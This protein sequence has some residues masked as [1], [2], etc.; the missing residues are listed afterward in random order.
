M[1]LKLRGGLDS[2]FVTILLGILIGS[3]AIFGIGSSAFN[4]NNQQVAAVGDTP[5]STETYYRRVQNRANGL[6]AQFGAQYT[7]PQLIS[8]LQI[9]QQVLQQMISEAALIEHT[10]S[11]GLRAGNAELRKELE[12]Y[13]GFVLPDGTLSKE[14]VLQAINNTGLTRT[15]FMNEV[16][17]SISQRK[18]IDTLSNDTMMPR[19]YAEAL[20]VWQAERRRATLIDI[21]AADIGDIP[22]PTDAELQGYYDLNK[23]AYRTDERR[24]YN[25]VLV[26]PQQFMADIKLDEEKVIAEYESR[27]DYYVQAER[28]GIQQVSFADKAAADA[29]LIA[30]NAGAEFVEAAASVTDFTAEEIE[31]GEFQK[32][33][34]VSTYNQVTADT[35]F[36]LADGAVTRP[37]KGLGGWNVFKVASITAAE[38]KSLEDVR[39]EIEAELKGFEAEE[40]MYEALDAVS[41]A[42]GEDTDLA[43]IAKASKLPLAT[44]TGVT[45]R[46]LNQNGEP[47]ATQQSEFTILRDA[48]SKEIGLEADMAD[49][50][51]RDSGKGFY[52]VEVTDII[53][54]A[55]RALED[56]KSELTKAWTQEQKLAK[57]SKIA[58]DAKNKLAAGADAETIAIDLN[59]TSFEAKNVA[60]T[61]DSNSSLSPSIRRLIFDLEKG[62]IDYD[63]AADGSGY[64]VVRVDDVTP[65]NPASRTAAVDKLLAQ[66]NGEAATE[67]YTQYR[68]YLLKT[69][70]ITVNNTLQQ[71][72]FTETLQQ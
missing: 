69:Y 72:L 43:L 21:K 18:L 49:I 66:L 62:G 24:T 28:R 55:D 70:D 56:I 22:A 57:A 17:A 54:P 31:L 44:V 36:A 26:T 61:G 47:V 46:G 33:E 15:D 1:L 34:L 2:I 7:T 40:H 63:R 8:M 5:I 65:G 48:F 29:F 16:R 42:M 68:N 25:Y 41:K 14:M 67:I 12:T 38:E 10:T 50:D 4:S 3:F 27:A 32:S 35:I 6:Q 64:I 53:P 37:L 71:S 30:V 58:E 19:Q 23:S 51:P 9:D 39:D 52:L 11:L 20:F 60:R 59:A 13:D 45:A